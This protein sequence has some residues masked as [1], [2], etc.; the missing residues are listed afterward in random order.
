MEQVSPPKLTDMGTWWP[1][2]A[3]RTLPKRNEIA[4]NHNDE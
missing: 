1:K 4:M 3:V 2:A